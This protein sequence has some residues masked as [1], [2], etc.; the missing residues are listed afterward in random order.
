MTGFCLYI[1]SEHLSGFA[2]SMHPLIQASDLI[3]FVL[4]STFWMLLYSACNT[5][6]DDDLPFRIVANDRSCCPIA[7]TASGFMI[8]AIYSL[9][10][11]VLL[12]RAAMDPHLGDLD[13]V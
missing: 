9:L 2:L 6:H 3:I 12:A 4:H 7:L 10:W 8:L 1:P 13:A 5:T 11:P